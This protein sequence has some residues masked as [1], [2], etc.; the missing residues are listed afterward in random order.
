[1]PVVV[2]SSESDPTPSADL[3]AALC[4]A[5]RDVSLDARGP[6]PLQEI[7]KLGHDLA[8]QWAATP[9]EA[10]VAHGWQA[11]VAAQIAV[12]GRPIPVL[13]R[14]S[15]LAGPAG[16]VKRA[17]L[18]SALAR[19]A[20][21]VLA[22]HT[23]Q[24]EQLIAIG[25]RRPAIRVV[26]FGVDISI[27]S[28]GGPKWAPTPRRRLVTAVTAADPATIA[29]LVHSLRALP[30]AELIV[31]G[32]HETD[33]ARGRL[34]DQVARRG[35]ADR[36]RL[37]GALSAEDRAA[38]LRSATVAISTMAEDTAA[39]FVLQAMA[40]GVPVVARAVGAAADAVA[41]GVTGVLLPP[42]TSDSTAEAVRGLLADALRR[43]SFGLAAVDRARARF[44]WTVA[45]GATGRIL[46][47]VTARVVVLPRQAPVDIGSA[48]PSG[49]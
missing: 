28:E 30:D 20:D 8:E 4:R 24:V 48:V 46:D 3:T 25:V 47:E 11:G 9:P 13:Q 44:N 31:F 12:Q 38:L 18:E 19:G 42:R 7:S 14:F 39:A 29:G 32:F 45:A 36:V 49:G 34:L 35:V 1:M 27:Y 21:R 2:L 16:D 17:R 41:D 15:G 43:E 22:G 23:G 6:V 26:P 10:V 33:A 5:G 40:C 37:L